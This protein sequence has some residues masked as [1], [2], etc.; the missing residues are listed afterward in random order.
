MLQANNL[1]NNQIVGTQAQKNIGIEFKVL[2]L[3]MMTAFGMQLTEKQIYK[4]I[5]TLL[6]QLNLPRRKGLASIVRNN[7]IFLQSDGLIIRQKGEYKISEKGVPLGISA[8]NF[9]R[10]QLSN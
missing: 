5:Q 1:Q 6:K 4:N 7:L 3:G 8:L 9:F 2:L 10:R